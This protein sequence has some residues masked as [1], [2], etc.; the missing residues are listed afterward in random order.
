MAGKG[1]RP[2][3][4]AALALSFLIFGG[5]D[6]A[7]QKTDLTLPDLATRLSAMTAVTGYEQSMVDSLIDL[8]PGA[9]RDGAGNAVVVLGSGQ[10][11]RLAACPVSEPGFVVGSVRSDGWLTLRRAPGRV[12][13]A[14]ERQLEG[15]RVR[16][17]GRAGAVPGVIGV[18]SI[19]L[20]RGRSAGGDVAFTVDSA[21]LD[22]GAATPAE[23]ASAGVGVLSPL[24]MT[25]RPQRYGSDLLAAPVA[26]R[27]TA[28]AALV[29]A[30]RQA[31]AE[32]G[33]VPRDESVVIAFVVEQELLGR[34]LA[35]V[36]NTRGPFAETV[37]VDGGPGTAG[38]LD[39]A[40]DTL[41]TRWPAL[42][43]VARWTLGARYSGT[44]VETTSLRGADSLQVALARWLGA[45]Q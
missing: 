17:F 8:V 16:V 29:L 23:V 37:V 45:G 26:A 20:T 34:G 22:I 41:G 10:R 15:Q 40:A 21:Y 5:G 43:K 18:R 19:H 44:A 31:A 7:A 36:A 9:T 4:V 35:T 12:P 32:Q 6:L 1:E 27:R 30:A 13:P 25:K 33:M 24:A 11:R 28:C 14:G 3:I 39:R 2:T 38:G 42:G